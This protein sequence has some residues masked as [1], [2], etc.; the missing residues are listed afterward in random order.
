VSVYVSFI[1]RLSLLR[2]YMWKHCSVFISAPFFST[3]KL[4]IVSSIVPYVCSVSM[5]CCIWNLVC[6]IT[7]CSLYLVLKFLPVCPVYLNWHPLHFIWYIPL[8][9]YLSVFCFLGWRRRFCIVFLGLYAIHIFVFLNNLVIIL[10]SFPMYV[11][12]AHFCFCVVLC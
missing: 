11:N 2:L 12:V 3:C 4:S 7:L 6:W 10:V 5:M 8:L 9:L 1:C